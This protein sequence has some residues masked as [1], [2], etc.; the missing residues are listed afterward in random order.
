MLAVGLVCVLASGAST[1]EPASAAA[2]SGPTASATAPTAI[3]GLGVNADLRQYEPAARQAVLRRLAQAGIRQIRQPVSWAELEQEPGRIR[4]ADLDE[5]VADAEAHDLRLLLALQESPDWA[6]RSPTP[7]SNL[8]LCDDPAVTG[9]AAARHA[10]PTDAAD[11]ASFAARLASRYRDR[12]WA[13]EVWPEPNLLP[14]WRSTGPDPENYGALLSTVA[15]AVR[16]AAPEVLVVSGGL[17]P[18]TDVGVCFLSDVVFLDRLARAGALSDVDAVGIEPFGLR[19]GPAAGPADREHLNFR[20]AE[21]L[22]DVLVRHGVD[23]PLWAV[24]WGWSGHEEQGERAAQGGPAPGAAPDSPWGRHPPQVAASWDRQ[25]FALA[26]DRWPWLTEMFLWHLQPAATAGDP[27]WGFALLDQTGQPTA[28]WAAAADLAA[29]RWPPA[30]AGLDERPVSPWRWAVLA[31]VLL[32]GA[33]LAVRR[34]LGPWLRRVV[35]PFRRLSTVQ[36]GALY[37]VAILVDIVLPWPASLVAVPVLAIVATVAPVVAVVAVTVVTPFYYGLD[38]WLGPQAFDGIE[39]LVLAAVGGRLLAWYLGPGND[40]PQLPLAP[41]P[42]PARWRLALR[43][44]HWADWLVVALIAWSALSISWSEFPGPAGRQWRTVMLEPALLYALLRSR[45]APRAVARLALDGLVVGGVL[46][47]ASG[48]VAVALLLLGWGGAG[49]GAEGVLRAVGPYASPNNLALLLGRLVPVVAVY[50]LWATGRRRR[51]YRLAVPVVLLGLVAT[52]SRGALLVGLP[53]VALYL[54][55]AA[56]GR[57]DRRRLLTLGAV[58]AGLATLVLPFAATERIRGAFRFAPGGTGFIRLRLWQSAVDMG[59]DHPWGGVGLDNF[60][61][62]YRDRYVRRDAVQERFLNHPHN[63]LLDWWTRLGVVGLGLFLAL[64]A[65][66]LQAGWRGWS[67]VGGTRLLAVAALGMQGY[68]LAHGL[69]DNSF[70]LV[71]LAVVWWVGQAALLS[72]GDAP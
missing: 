33:V 27:R 17:A 60:L 57:A 52:F 55:A 3:P 70:F 29:G 69:V 14:N 26:R 13:V 11:L 18:T 68:A 2:V 46:A 10:P 40:R 16:A 53:V 62:L 41:G 47:A 25:A 24:A 48:L 5:L 22:H 34:W 67:R 37:G 54:A 51:L 44:L 4:W 59:W 50:A 15:T 39:F 36:L 65:A 23:R 45:P 71:D 72:V 61:Y 12:L 21:V 66:N 1:V 19:D 8:W 64:V 43:R 32:G 35:R 9:A 31:A 30:A 38:M 20:R 58:L 6:R 63:W 42:G 7:P 49:V 56:L 28:L